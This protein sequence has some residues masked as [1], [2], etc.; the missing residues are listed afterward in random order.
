M[1]ANRP[2]WV[3]SRQRAWGVPIAR[4][5]AR[6]GDG[7]VEILQD[8]AVNAAHRRSVRG[9]RRRR[10]VR[11]GRR[12][13]ASSA[14]PTPTSDWKKVDD[15]LDVWFDSGST[16]A[17]V[18]EDPRHFPQL[19]GIKRT[20]PRRQR[21]RDVS[22]RLRPASRL[23]SFLAAG[24]LRHARRRA[25]RRR[26]DARLRPRRAR[27]GQDVEVARQ[28]GRAA[29]RYAQS[30][31]DILR[32]WVCASDYADDLRIGKEILKNYDRDLP[33][34]RNTLRWMLG[35]LAHFRPEDRVEPAQM[36]E[37]ERL[38][39]HDLDRAGRECAPRAT[40]R[41]TTSAC[42]AR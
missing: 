1:I 3:M 42:S 31:A 13:S 26:A 25:I 21:Y 38:M 14:R 18:L 6:K 16:H 12:A 4:V 20:D 32:L 37:L 9:R 17:F 27:P 10:L 24:E 35:N 15:I 5:R 23:V 40:R 7:S 8:E 36:P 33:Q 39:L 19:A 22:G 2:D 11:G 34:L 30:G 28:R 29:G 41:S